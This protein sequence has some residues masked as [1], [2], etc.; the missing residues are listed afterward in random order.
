MPK[1][2]SSR[3]PMMSQLSEEDKDLFK[4]MI[5]VLHLFYRQKEALFAILYELRAENWEPVYRALQSEP[6][7][8]KRADEMFSFFYESIERGQRDLD[9]LAQLTKDDLKKWEPN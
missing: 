6:S 8:A 4:K 3:K 7:I 9:S 1:K 5:D 2:K